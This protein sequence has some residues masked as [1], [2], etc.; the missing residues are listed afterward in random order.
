MKTTGLSSRIAVF[1]RPFASAGSDG[2]TTFRPGTCATHAC[3]LWLC[4]AAER[5]VAPIV[6]RCVSGTFSFPPDM[7]CVFAAWFASWSITSVRKS[8][9]MMSTTGRSPVIAAPTP[10][11]VMPGSEMGVSRTRSGPNSST[12]PERTL[13]GVPAS[14]TSSPMTNTVGSRR[15]SSASASLTARA[16]VSSGIHVLR[17][18]ARVGE[19]R[20]ECER[21]P[22]LDLRTGLVGDPL[23]VGRRR[24]LVL[25]E[26]RPQDREWVALAPPEL[27]LLLRPVIRPV[28]VA[29]VMAVV[30]VR[31]AEQERRA[32]A[33]ACALDQL[34]R[35]RVH[36]AHV[37]PVDLARLDAERARPG[38]NLAGSRLEVVRVLVVLVVLADVDHGQLPERRHVHDLVDEPLAERPLAEEAD[39]DLV[40]PAPLRRE[41]GA[42]RDAR[43]AA[44]DRVRAEIP[45]LVIGNVHGAALAAAVAGLLAEQLREHPP[46]LGALGEAVS[47]P[48]VRGGDPVVAPQRRADADRD[49]LLADVEVGEARHLRA[50]VELVR[51]LL[52]QADE[53]HAPVHTQ[54]ELGADL[55]ARGG[56]THA[57]TSVCTPDIA[58]STSNNTAKSF[59]PMPMPFAAVRNSFVTAVVGSGTS[60]SRPS[61][62]ARFMS[63]CI[64]WQSNQ[65]SSGCPSTSGPR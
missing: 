48:A 28:D 46:R 2:K 10:R 51:M 56:R 49:R 5:R 39:G 47:V 4:C 38:E 45:V 31:V 8:P 3:R 65:T 22:G 1:S 63:F 27:L 23:Q 30:A 29:D 7:S 24:E 37:L 34:G 53:R 9:N 19:R 60:S 16:N 61:S 18:L 25:P 59:S 43:G 26:P 32:A 44:D 64:M 57:S 15:S 17:H 12:R 62:R 20:V 6:V 21:E 13:N 40:G 41:R 42:R 36:R 11:P 52:E 35:L 58:A 14:A 50:A 55:R 54:R 33:A